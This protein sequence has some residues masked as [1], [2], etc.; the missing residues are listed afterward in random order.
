M[1]EKRFFT[2]MLIAVLMP[3]AAIAQTVS[4]TYRNQALE[5]VFSDFK[6]QTGYEFVY[7]TSTLRNQSG[8]TATFRNTNLSQALKT[9]LQD[10]GLSF[11]IKDKTVAIRSNGKQANTV[12]GYVYDVTTRQP[13]IGA[14]V[15]EN[16]TSNGAVTDADGH[17]SLRM[18]NGNGEL[19]ITY[20]GFDTY[21]VKPGNRHELKVYMRESKNEMDEVVVN[22]I[23]TIEKGRATGAFNILNQKTMANVYSNT[24]DDKLEGIVPGLYVDS[25]EGIVIRGVNTLSAETKPLLVVDGFPME[26]SELNINPNDIEQV[27][28]LKDAASA[29]IWGIRAANGVIVVTTKHGH[30]EQKATVD[31]SSTFTIGSKPDWDDLNLLSSDEYVGLNFQAYLDRGL[32][33]ASYYGPDEIGS[34][35]RS[36]DN[37]DITLDQAWNQ[38]NELGKFNNAKQIVDNFYRRPFT[39]QHNIS[40]SGGTKNISSYVSLNFDQ[41]NSNLKG[42]EYYKFN[43]LSN[44]DIQLH[45]KFDVMVG[46]RGTYIKDNANGTDM[47]NTE[48][49]KRILNDDGTYYDQNTSIKNSAWRDRLY[50]IGFKDWS[51]NSLQEMRNNDN[52]TSTYNISAQL[53][54]QWK[55]VKGLT[56]S[57]QGSYEFSNAENNVYYSEDSYYTRNLVNTFTQVEMG[58]DGLPASIVK[59]NIPAD[60][61]IKDITTT[62]YTSYSLRNTISYKNTF[63]GFD[64][65]A[66]FGNEVYQRSGHSFYDRMFGFNPDLLTSQSVDVATLQGGVRTWNGNSDNIDFE[67]DYSEVMERYVSYFGTASVS[68]QDKY[69]LFG[70][71]RVDKTNLLTNASKFRNSPSWSVGAKWDAGSEKFIKDVSWIDNLDVRLAYGKSGNIDKTTSPDMVARTYS[72]Y[73]IPSLNYLTVTNPSNPYL[74]WEKTYSLNL[75]FDFSLFKNIL[76]GTLDLYHKT[77]DGLLANVETDP[78]V[79]WSSVRMNS[80]KVTNKG[81]DLSLRG[82][83]INNKRFGWASTLNFSYNHNEVTKLY[84]TPTVSGVISS[85]GNT[86]I[87]GQPV[88][89]IATVRYGGLDENGEPTFLKKGDSAQHPYSELNSLTIDDVNFNGPTQPPFFGSWINEFRYSDFTLAFMFTYK[90]GHKMH[91][92]VPYGSMFGTYTKWMSSKYR[93]V[94]GEDNTDK[95]VPYFYTASAYQPSNRADCF[96]ESDKLIDDADVIYLKSVS[97]TYDASRWLNMI[98][99]RGGY[100]KLSGENLWF[101]AANKYDLDPDQMD[102]ESHLFEYTSILRTNTPRLVITLNVN[103]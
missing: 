63:K 50:E 17:F 34:I 7:Q 53:R 56:L 96:L 8:V 33:L 79:G 12:D 73:F 18:T 77:S 60:G 61:G 36:Y 30:K 84:Y 32:S 11:F 54:L 94:E 64:Y 1:R 48:P 31:Y 38:V 72:A 75:G 99:L 51:R 40:I 26:S 57:S 21:T 90:F 97:L 44:N 103:F 85:Y 41:K 45:P 87:K 69:N 25:K 9:V 27:T 49:W 98:G 76:S 2:T 5:K 91:L 62:R 43:F 23:Q 47:T 59:Y 20:V 42:N 66:M 24:L 29:S 22:G 28:V 39:Q 55:P 58:D 100:L 102:S 82:N 13:L 67:Q 95:Y 70:S 71:F 93:W 92:P 15:R 4:G 80:A 65:S 19:T 10:R 14:S 74:G 78:T 89:Y 3:L 37:G 6:R 52:S 35:Y 68:W 88:G 46:L 86:P 16:G 81:I 83:I 101:W